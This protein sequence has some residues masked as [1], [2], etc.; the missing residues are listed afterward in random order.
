M[1]RGSGRGRHGRG[2]PGGGRHARR[3]AAGLLLALLPAAGA[4]AEPGAAI[5]SLEVV[6]PDPAARPLVGERRVRRWL[7]P[8]LEDGCDAAAARAALERRYRFLGYVPRVEARCADGALHLSIRE[9]SHAIARIAFDPAELIGLGLRIDPAFEDRRRLHPVPPDGPRP[10][11]RA[12]LQTREGDLY[13]HERYRAERQALERLGYTLAFVPLPPRGDDYPA[14]AY[15][16][17]SLTPPRDSAGDPGR[18]RN[19]LGG[20]ASHGPRRGAAVG[21][22]YQRQEL[23][24]RLDRLSVAPLYNASLGGQ[25]SYVAP[26]L[27]DRH[28]PA[29]LFDLTFDLYSDFV[30]NR[31]LQGIVTDQRTTGVSAVLGIRPVGVAGPHDLRLEAGLRHERLRLEETI[32]GEPEEN[33]TALRLGAAWT[34]RHT[35]RWP[36]LTLRLAPAVDVATARAGGDR[37][38]LRPG[39]EGNFHVRHLSGWETDLR[40]VAGTLD[41]SVPS[42]EQ[43]SLGG[44]ASVR[45]FREDF[46]L[47]RHLAALQAELWFPLARPLPAR[48]ET[49]GEPDQPGALPLE[50][51]VARHLKGALVLDGGYLSGTA[52]GVNLAVAGAGIGLR[53]LVPRRPIVVKIDYAW[54]LGGRG[55]DRFPYVALGYRF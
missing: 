12:L 20:N 43:W 35:D 18:R 26:L 2:R 34:Y 22:T 13:N 21:A 14:G 38:F 19:Y 36:S 37:G 10:A 4:G 46:A 11:L 5:R 31:L 41:R 32:P 47:G 50:R 23:F 33:L 16:V 24:G 48:L 1:R 55:G 7:R 3:V 29:A 25:L 17:Q 53:F 40:W 8:A 52:D 28:D 44:A 54:G 27:A 15:L 30:H 51:R 6:R 45:G 42:F 39:L 9:S 49:G